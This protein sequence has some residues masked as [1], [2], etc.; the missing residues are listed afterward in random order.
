[1]CTYGVFSKSGSSKAAQQVRPKRG[2][3]ACTRPLS[4]SQLP[5]YGP[6]PSFDAGGRTAP[7]SCI[8]VMVSSYL[9]CWADRIGRLFISV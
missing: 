8:P 6:E 7:A 3:S 1:M 5:S 4:S 9:V 2:I